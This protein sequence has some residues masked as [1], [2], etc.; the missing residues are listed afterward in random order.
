MR[1]RNKR[2]SS[3]VEMEK[4]SESEGWI[5]ATILST[6]DVFEGA[7]KRH[8]PHGRGTCIRV[9]SGHMYEGQW[10]SESGMVKES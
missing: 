10:K 7:M 4:F 9:S 5:D 6:G 3:S 8:R 1:N 2:R